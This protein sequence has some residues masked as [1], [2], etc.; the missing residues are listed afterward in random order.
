MISKIYRTYIRFC[1]FILKEERSIC[2]YAW[3]HQHTSIYWKMWTYIFN[4]NH[5]HKAF[6]KHKKNKPRKT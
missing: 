5:C 4:R 2:S 1:I 3:E 6:L